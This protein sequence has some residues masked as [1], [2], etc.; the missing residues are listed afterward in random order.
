MS[1]GRKVWAGTEPREGHQPGP[2]GC[3]LK[4]GISP[5]K[6]MFQGQEMFRTRGKFIKIFLKSHRKNHLG[7]YRNNNKTR[8]TQ[9]ANGAPKRKVKSI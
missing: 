5:G 8:I 3:T 9:G 4:S 1:C 7:I 6:T 2:E